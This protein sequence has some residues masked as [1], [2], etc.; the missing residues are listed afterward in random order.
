MDLNPKVT[1]L[2]LKYL[3]ANSVFTKK[4][5]KKIGYLSLSHFGQKSVR[6]KERMRF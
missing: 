5:K 6:L 2:G 1:I 4:K 3:N